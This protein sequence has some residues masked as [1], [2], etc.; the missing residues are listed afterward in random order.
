MKKYMR[1]IRRGDIVIVLLLM[2]GS[3]L[4]LGIFTYQQ[5]SAESNARQAV[6]Q[7]DGE[8]VKVFDLVDDGKTETFLY[9]D[10]EGH[11]NLIVRTG[12]SVDIAEANCRD[13]VCVRM[14]AIEQPGQ[15]MVCLPHKLL[16]EVVSDEPVDDGEA[17]DVIS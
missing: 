6:V 10:E 8:I 1:M 2:L 3:F 17:L 16:V 12:T 7:V 9:L 13:Q 5:A 4:P 11:E 14:L 15:T